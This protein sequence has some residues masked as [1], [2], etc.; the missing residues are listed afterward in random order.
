MPFML[1]VR[2]TN[3]VFFVYLTLYLQSLVFGRWMFLMYD[4]QKE[5]N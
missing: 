4:K 5:N 3:Y 1:L 2:I